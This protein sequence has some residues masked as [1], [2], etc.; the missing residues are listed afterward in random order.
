LSRIGNFGFISVSI[1]ICLII[2]LVFGL[3]VC[4]TV[5]TNGLQLKEV[6]GFSLNALAEKDISFTTNFSAG[7]RTANFF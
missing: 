4:H 5:A 7:Q 3:T 6:G 1:F 2:T